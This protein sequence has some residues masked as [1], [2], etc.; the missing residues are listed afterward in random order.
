MVARQLQNFVGQIEIEPVG[1]FVTYGIG[2]PAPMMRHPRK[3]LARARL[4]AG[5]LR[6]LGVAVVAVAGVVLWA[7]MMRVLRVYS[8]PVATA[9]S[10]AREAS[11]NRIEAQPSGEMTE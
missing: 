4:T 8:V 6:F 1:R 10:S 2:I 7:A 9:A 11:R 3:A 5:L